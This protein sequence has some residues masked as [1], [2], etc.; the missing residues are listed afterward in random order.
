[1]GY[2]TSVTGTAVLSGSTQAVLVTT[3]LLNEL[4][5]AYRGW[6]HASNAGP[7]FTF[8]RGGATLSPT[9]ELTIETLDGSLIGQRVIID[10][11]GNTWRL[12]TVNGDGTTLVGTNGASF[13]VTAR[14]A[15]L[16]NV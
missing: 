11:G 14:A 2:R 15:D 13:P 7:V 6:T 4:N 8:Y 16:A 3:E 10:V 9:R 1:M 5:T 12:G